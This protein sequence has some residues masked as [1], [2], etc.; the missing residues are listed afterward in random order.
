MYSL[1]AFARESASIILSTVISPKKQVQLLRQIYDKR[2]PQNFLYSIIVCL[3]IWRYNQKFFAPC[4]SVITE[5][6]RSFII[7]GNQTNL[8]FYE[9]DALVRIVIICTLILFLLARNELRDL[10]RKPKLFS[11]Y[12]TSI[13][14]IIL[15]LI[16]MILPRYFEFTPATGLPMLIFGGV[17]L[18]AYFLLFNDI[19]YIF[20]KRNK[21]N[22]DYIEISIKY[23]RVFLP[24]IIYLY[25]V[26]NVPDVQLNL[27]Y[28]FNFILDSDGMINGF[29][30]IL[31][32]MTI[33]SFYLVISESANERT[34]EK[35]TA[36]LMFMLSL[37]IFLYVSLRLLYLL[38]NPDTVTRDRWDLDWGFMER[39]NPFVINAWPIQPNFPEDS[40]W[41]VLFAASI[42]S[43]RVTIVSIFFCTL[44]GIVI[45]VTRLSNNRIASG[46]AT[47]YVEV[48]RNMPL[49]VLLFLVSLELG[50]G[51]P[52]FTDESNIYGLIYY[53]NQGIFVPKLDIFRVI[54]VL[55]VLIFV[56]YYTSKFD[57]SE[58]SIKLKNTLW[59]AA[60]FLSL[61]LILSGM[62]L[63]IYDKPNLKI[64]GTWNIVEGSGFE[65]TIEFLAMII[66]LTLF[67]AAVVAEIVRGSIQALP[68]GQVEAAVSLGL[69]PYQ[70]IKLVILPQA[71][72]SM[73]PLLNS[74]Y[75]NIW[76]NSSL[77]IIVAYS[78]IFYV[79]FV[80]MNNVGKL[81]PLF[82]L[83]LV[84]YQLG[85][86]SISAV[87]N[88]YNNRITKVK[89]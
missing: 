58:G 37:P 36:S 17:L 2:I 52:L 46:L 84:I 59:I 78:D 57:D 49:A 85:S 55:I 81:I 29:S 14:A 20:Q 30:F 32:I 33:F 34:Q 65:I 51:L 79:I 44:L 54:I 35:R 89:I 28:Y 86:L 83:L 74:Q 4:L 43:I 25:C 53:S 10:Y 6:S 77:A 82:L 8:A 87:M 7:N 16:I 76:K 13:F 48:F 69:S 63:P 45:G 88:L 21:S 64:P 11:G 23:T 42:N 62:S 72:R 15:S 41:Q 19:E 50:A 5:M 27:D 71:L 1:R 67:T 26:L 9:S 38:N 68:R 39:N 22:T 18:L 40:R 12:A 73:I 80:T 75:M 61:G 70:R 24:L 47:V 31:L 60:I 66:G 56:K 3:I